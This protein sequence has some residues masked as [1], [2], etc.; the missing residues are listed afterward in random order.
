MCM[1]LGGR[2]SEEIFFGRITTGAQDDLKKVTQSAYAQI[3]HY[4][5]NEK[6]GNVSF[7][8][9]QPGE[10]VLEKPYSEETA[11]L[12][13]SEVR[14]LI[15]AAHKHTHQLLKQHKDKVEKVIWLVIP[16]VDLL[17]RPTSFRLQVFNKYS[18]LCKLGC[19]AVVK[20]RNSRPWRHD[21]VTGRPTFPRKVHLRT[22]RWRNGL[23]WGRH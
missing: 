13:D 9:P 5:M 17:R 23:V 20:T 7:D 2:V 1:T 3:V 11:Q 12:I 22:V 19:R 16:K 14:V 10:A 8:M 6:V 21:R 15:G 18:V 4:G